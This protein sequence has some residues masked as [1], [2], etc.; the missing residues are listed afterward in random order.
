[1]RPVHITEERWNEVDLQVKALH[2]TD[3]AVF[4]EYEWLMMC[5]IVRRR[6]WP[7]MTN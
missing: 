1:M 2:G 6:L 3:I 5:M 7:L 4:A